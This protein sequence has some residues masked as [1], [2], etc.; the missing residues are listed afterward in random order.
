[1]VLRKRLDGGQEFGPTALLGSETELVGVTE[2]R[3]VHFADVAY[4][5]LDVYGAL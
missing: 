2:I 4:A 1:L 5:L 3:L